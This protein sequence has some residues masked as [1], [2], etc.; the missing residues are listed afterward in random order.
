MRKIYVLLFV[1]SLSPSITWAQN[2]ISQ[3]ARSLLS[4]YFHSAPFAA[5]GLALVC[6]K[7]TEH[8]GCIDT[9]G[10]EIIPFK[11][12]LNFFYFI[13]EPPQF[14]SVN[15]MVAAKPLTP[16]HAV[17]GIIN[18]RGETV[19]PFEYETDYHNFHPLDANHVFK[20][21]HDGR[22][23]E[24][25]FYGV[26]DSLGTII[27]PFKYDKIEKAGENRFIVYQ[28]NKPSLFDNRGKPIQTPD[29]SKILY[30]FFFK[31]LF[32][33]QDKQWGVYSLNGEE[34]LP[35]QHHSVNFMVDG[36]Y[37][38]AETS[39]SINFYKNTGVFV[40]GFPIDYPRKRVDAK[41]QTTFPIILRH[42]KKEGMINNAL[43]IIIPFEY[44]FLN[45]PY[46]LPPPVGLSPV[47]F[48]AKKDGKET[49]ID[50]TNTLLSG[51][52]FDVV[53]SDG[54]V[55]KDGLWGWVNGKAILKVPP[56]YESLKPI[57]VNKVLRWN[58]NPNDYY[59]IVTQNGKTGLLGHDNKLIV[60]L[61]KDQ[62]MHSAY[63]PENDKPVYIVY[64][65]GGKYG[66]IDTNGKTVIPFE[67][68]SVKTDFNLFMHYEGN[69]LFKKGEEVYTV[70]WDTFKLQKSQHRF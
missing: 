28:N 41:S 11:Y 10:K 23:K 22:S 9:M 54:L 63:R 24:P 30:N 31:V 40:K 14:N 8:C 55:K 34:I 53:A 65:K 12:G 4:E 3:R 64:K 36:S 7:D 33:E 6:K 68:D 35:V 5:N 47:I 25:Q 46:N 37:I 27:I 17:Y 16:I 69:Y 70:N 39:D 59:L 43:K 15:R 60:P 61:G 44:D 21:Y 52:W 56:Q 51:M 49:Y 20:T 29:F 13:N 2:N 18:E 45:T 42:N 48:H 1:L 67:F 19:L 62:E 66:A 38:A 26:V 58:N 57:L 32:V 50:T